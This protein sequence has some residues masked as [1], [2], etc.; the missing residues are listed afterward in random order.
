MKTKKK[1]KIFIFS[2]VSVCLLAVSVFAYLGVSLF[3]DY[4]ENNT[5]YTFDE[6]TNE[7]AEL[8][9]YG[10]DKDFSGNIVSTAA[11]DFFAKYQQCIFKPCSASRENINMAR[12]FHTYYDAEGKELFV[13]ESLKDGEISVT[14]DGST[15]SYSFSIS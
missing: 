4:Q 14:V 3:N 12:F 7:K 5:V 15:R 2:V 8:V 13:I 9:A 10:E 1:N 6:I 11:M